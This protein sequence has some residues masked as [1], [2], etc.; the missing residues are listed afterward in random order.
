[1]PPTEFTFTNKSGQTI[2]AAINL[3]R[4]PKHKKRLPEEILVKD[5]EFWNKY[6]ER[7][8]GNWITQETTVKEV[9]EWARRIYLRRDLTVFEGDPIFVRDNDAQKAF[10]KLRSAV[11]ALYVWRYGTTSD[12]ALKER[13][14]READ[15]AFRQAFAFGPINPEVSF[16]YVN[17][18]SSRGHFED[19]KLIAQTLNDT[20]PNSR[21]AQILLPQ[22]LLNQERQLVAKRDYTKAAKVALEM[23]QLDANNPDHLVRH[24]YYQR[25]TQ[26][27]HHFIS[28]FNNT[29][30]NTTN[31]L[32]VIQMY[33]G[34]R[35]TNEIIQ[36][37]ELYSQKSDTNSM[38]LT[39]I[40]NA[41]GLIGDWEGKLKVDLQLTKH[42]PDSYA[43]WFD[44]SQTHIRLKQTNE[45]TQ[46]MLKALDLFD[47]SGTKIP[48]II[49]I[50]RTN[51]LL[52]PLREQPEIKNIL[53]NN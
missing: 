52:K 48:D 45:S 17:F 51:R 31:F 11:A 25:I 53:R 3:R 2:R 36:A 42:E 37:I 4:I 1:M 46:A 7:L 14:A 9:C 38:S 35:K 43:A 6:S 41:Y 33:G 16:K 10:S 12:Q 8:I 27:N 34:M 30:N 22:I 47:N 15:F 18:L 49:P 28:A 24:Q 19:A 32:R 44:L 13:Y 5:R 23:A 21:A 40:K 50:L 29:P 26:Q 20:D 39:A